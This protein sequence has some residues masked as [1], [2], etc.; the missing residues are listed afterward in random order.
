MGYRNVPSED[1]IR[2]CLSELENKNM[3][4]TNWIA[5]ILHQS[6]V[7][8]TLLNGKVVKGYVH[9]INLFSEISFKLHMEEQLVALKKIIK[10]AT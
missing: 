7:C 8:K 3:E 6:D 9:D 5:N 4:T 2:K 10:N 1:V